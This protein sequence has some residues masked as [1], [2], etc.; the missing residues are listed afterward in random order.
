MKVLVLIIL[1]VVIA[2]SCRDRLSDK[3]LT[4]IPG[5]YIRFSAHEFGTEF[6][7]LVIVRERNEADQFLITRRWKYERVL[8]GLKMEPEYKRQVTSCYYD[9]KRKTLTE[10]E[11][12]DFYSFDPGRNMLYAGTTKYMKIK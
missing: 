4:F 1:I 12:G 5:T 8:D 7:T 2:I 11:T 3:V 6:D 10:A 9:E